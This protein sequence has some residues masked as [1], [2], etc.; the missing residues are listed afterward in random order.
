MKKDSRGDLEVRKFMIDSPK[1]KS[2][3]RLTYGIVEDGLPLY[4]VNRWLE[5]YSINSYLT[6]EAYAYHILDYLRYLKGIKVHYKK[7]TNKAVIENY[8]KYLL[9][10]K[11]DGKVEI[12][13]D[14]SFKSTKDRISV[15]KQFYEWLEDEAEI[16]NNP[17]KYGS[18]ERKNGNR[19]VKS[20]FL[21]GQIWRFNIEENTV[22]SKLRYKVSQ[23][24]I[25]WY[26][27]EEIK[28]IYKALPTLRDK[29]IFAISIE[30]GMRIGEI[31]GLKLYDIDTNQGE[32][33][34]VKDENIEN[35]ARAKT[36][37]RTVYISKELAEDLDLYIRGERID[38]LK[39][40]SEFLF[41]NH[42]GKYKGKPTRTRNFL[43]IL[44]T[45]ASKVGFDPK[46]IRTHSGRSTAAETLVQA[47]YD[48]KVTELFI[49]EQLGMSPKTLKRYIKKHQSK[50]RAKVAK[51][52]VET[53]IAPK[54]RE[55]E[56][57]G[58]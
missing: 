26:E 28:A 24:H 31:L 58:E 17:V 15:V 6:A 30:T 25:K 44:K 32:I 27:D 4:E 11:T 23:D 51:D 10:E 38:S 1:L 55:K 19:H 56:I 46:N 16:E 22:T 34:I 8:V 50:G 43:R 41:L 42:K 36:T 2:G 14:K 20:K 52:I 35:A 53:R 21:Y 9:Y 7:V 13:G 54:Y 57:G 49:V 33:Q 45:A 37:E 39:D 47:M 40:N 18:K 48:G 3:V 5:L 12:R 29:N